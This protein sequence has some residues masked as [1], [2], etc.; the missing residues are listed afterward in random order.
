MCFF[1]LCLC[2]GGKVVITSESLNKNLT[3]IGLR[4]LKDGAGDLDQMEFCE[5]LSPF[6]GVQ[7][8]RGWGT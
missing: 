2:I 7:L 8:G 5:R 4:G 1:F 3:L 6:I